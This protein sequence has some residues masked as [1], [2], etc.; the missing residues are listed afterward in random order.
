MHI[1]YLS[2]SFI[3]FSAAPP[4]DF[5]FKLLTQPI[6]G[7]AIVKNAY[8]N[9]HAFDHEYDLA[10]VPNIW[11]LSGQFFIT[12]WLRILEK[13]NVVVC[14]GNEF[15]HW[16]CIRLYSLSFGSNV[17]KKFLNV[18]NFL[19]CLMQPTCNHVSQ[20]TVRYLQSS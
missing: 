8:F 6:R 15:G 13:R 14:I 1:L 3:W 7:A 12:R 17:I 20:F 2:L 9:Y 19:P 4:E 11:Y 5:Y 18:L 10:E 16:L